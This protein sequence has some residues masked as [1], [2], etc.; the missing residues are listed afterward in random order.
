[1]AVPLIAGLSAA[2]KA[3]LRT[4][5]GQRAIERGSKA[6]A[7]FLKKNDPDAFKP[8][9]KM[10]EAGQR[11][12]KTMKGRRRSQRVIDA[13]AAGAAGVVVGRDTKKSVREDWRDMKAKA[14]EEERQRKARKEKR[15]K[16]SK[17]DA[18]SATLLKKG[19]PVAKTRDGIAMRGKTRAPS[20]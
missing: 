17:L 16:R 7:R 19:G 3:L 8:S 12:Q 13:T 20:R 18:E 2:A 9:D 14:I 5:A 11:L 6:V 10:K 15:K 1:M 4:P